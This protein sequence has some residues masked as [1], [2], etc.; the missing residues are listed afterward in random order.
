V[1]LTFE[2]ID[3]ILV[4]IVLACSLNLLIGYSGVFSA[5]PAA[6]ALVGGY[7]LAELWMHSVGSLLV[8]FVILAA[9]TLLLG[10]IV[11]VLILRLPVLW[12]VLLTLSVQ[13]VLLGFVQVG[14][15]FGGQ[16]GLQPAGMTIFGHKLDVPSDVFPFLLAF[17]IVT[18][19]VCLRL[20]ES[21][22]GRVLRAV[23]DDSVAAQAIGKNVTAYK[24]KVF[25]FTSMLAGIGGA[26]LT[27]LTG[28]ATP[29]LFSFNVSV[30]L[31][32]MVI[33]GGMANL[34]GSIIGVAIVV[35]LTP[36][37]QN[38]LSL[39]SN[40]AALWQVVAYGLAL[41]LFVFFRPSGLI[42]EGVSVTSLAAHVRARRERAL[43]GHGKDG[44]R[45]VEAPQI[46]QVSA[47][48]TQVKERP[49]EQ[50]AAEAGAVAVDTVAVNTAAG[51]TVVSVRGLAK[52]FGGIRAV[53]GLSLELAKG[54]VTA[55]V[56]PN[57]AGKTT[58]FNLLTGFIPPDRGSVK[59]YGEEVRGLRPDQIAK[60]GM[61]RSF[62]DVRL[63]PA[64]TVLENVMVGVQ[65]HP[66]EDFWRVLG[67][68]RACGRREREVRD[69]AASCLEFTGMH[70]S[71]THK[72]GSLGYGQ[73][74]LV[75]LARILATG[76]PVL[77]LDEPAS[78]IDRR[79]V[80]EI[81]D[82]IRRLRD[83]GRTICIVEHN[84]H[85]VSEISDLVY[86]MELG[87]C[88]ARGSFAELRQETR[89]A[90]AYF[91]TQGE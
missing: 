60:R 3:Q 75:A 21:P 62:Q 14:T 22:Y 66:G 61:V 64:L 82:I 77:L 26:L 54:R 18:F 13:L 45:R 65:G 59:L 15:R 7:A 51:E 11:G 37:F 29:S 35:L 17:A 39:S 50:P 25:A 72:A 24:I 55:L 91:G 49:S 73:Q 43:A 88:T 16:Y 38:V 89:L 86:F 28:L 85:V 44:P 53:N 9:I 34:Y 41:V 74:K 5:G 20:G 48:R 1:Q 68:M 27:V 40:V 56:G 42:P 19:A 32:A 71:A 33:I 52:S 6:F 36:F 80:E 87:R 79:W 47:G 2:Y 67:Q 76:S 78:G 30:E 58:V 57:G 81:L 84:L 8:D 10:A 31:I 12:V 83:E 63:F 70:T 23:R 69:I 4:F 46:P 90:H